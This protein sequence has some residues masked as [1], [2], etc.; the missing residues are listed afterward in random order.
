MKIEYNLKKERRTEEFKPTKPIGFGQLE[1]DHM[2]VMDYHLPK[3]ETDYSKGEWH[4]PKIMPMQPFQ[5]HP[6]SLVLHYAQEIFEGAKAFQHP[7]SELYAFRID[8]NAKR[9][10]RSAG[11]MC[12]PKIP[13]KDQLQGIEALLDVDRLWFPQQ[14]EASMYIRPFMFATTP[15]LG[16]KAG[17]D[18]RFCVLLSPS[19][20]YYSEGFNPIRLL[21]TEEFKRVP[22]K[23]V[24][25]AKAGGNYGASLRAGRRAGNFDAKQVLFLDVYNHHLEEAGAMNH[26]HVTRQE[27]VVIPQFTDTILESITSRSIIE[28]RKRLGL[29]V[30]QENI[31]AIDFLFGIASGRISEAGGLGT[32][33][34]VSPVGEY[35][36]DQGDIIR[37]GN[38]QVGPISR[39][40]YR[41]LTGIQNGRFEAPEGWLFKVRRL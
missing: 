33:A 38:G 10:N 41:L 40:M 12:M 27:E 25:Q 32:A 11:I 18:Y 13:V 17:N 3:R 23:G 15:S 22:P 39:K 7:D 9:F 16:V 35:I 5:I 24:G 34:V 20:P 8:K 1:S 28:L 37:V 29:H 30:K 14:E 6:R 4:S 31:S 36:S 19:G 26:Y 21:L 2:F